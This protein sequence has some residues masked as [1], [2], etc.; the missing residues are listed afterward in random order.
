MNRESRR[1]ARE[2]LDSSWNDTEPAAV[3]ESIALAHAHGGILRTRRLGVVVA[4]Y[5]MCHA[6]LRSTHVAV[7]HNAAVSAFLEHEPFDLRRSL[8][9]MNPPQH[10][11]VRAAI[12]PLF[13]Q[14]TQQPI[15]SIIDRFDSFVAQRAPVDLYTHLCEPL[16][17]RRVAHLLGTEADAL[18]APAMA[19]LGVYGQSIGG[20]RLATAAGDL[21][22]LAAAAL[23]T[24]APAPHV[25]REAV[26]ADLLDPS[27]AL[28]VWCDLAVAGFHTT[29]L[30]LTWTLAATLSGALALD[31]AEVIAGQPPAW[32]VSECLRSASPTRVTGRVVIEPHS[33]GGL[34]VRRGELLT[35]WL[36]AANHDGHVFS[37]PYRLR[38]GRTDTPLAFGGGIHHCLGAP[39]AQQ[40]LKEMLLACVSAAPLA[41]IDDAARP[42]A[43]VFGG[44]TRLVVTFRPNDT[45]DGAA[46]GS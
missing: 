10:T 24:D 3:R 42:S 15:D 37:D 9:A 21:R 36:E 44:L 12:A 17:R 45:H 20:T 34:D 1:R 28:D 13:R 31:P 2:Q 35:V 5:Q 19:L 40:Q 11:R 33:L 46:R 32:W 43:S 8:T 25:L 38:R 22:G 27:E 29:A 18:R 39:L 4:S 30:L 41:R 14:I 16:A 26:A 7:D 6:V 23:A